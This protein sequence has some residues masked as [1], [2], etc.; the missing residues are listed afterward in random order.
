MIAVDPDGP[1]FGTPAAVAKTCS[2]IMNDVQDSL[3]DQWPVLGAKIEQCRR[4]DGP[5]PPV[6]A[7]VRD[8]YHIAQQWRYH[9]FALSEAPAST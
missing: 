5:V 7:V 2:T 6:V 8:A 9:S 3:R 1:R 4:G